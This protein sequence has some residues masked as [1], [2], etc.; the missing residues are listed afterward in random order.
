MELVVRYAVRREP[1]LLTKC[2]FCNWQL[3][4]D[5][6][7]SLVVN[8]PALLQHMASAHLKILAL[9][10]LPSAR[11]GSSASENYRRELI[12]SVPLENAEDASPN[13]DAPTLTQIEQAARAIYVPNDVFVPRWI[14]QQHAA[15]DPVTDGQVSDALQDK[16]LMPQVY[17]LL[18]GPTGVGKSTF[19]RTASGDERVGIGH[20]LNSYTI[21]V[22]AFEFEHAGYR[23]TLLDTPGFNDTH[24]GETEVLQSI[25]E[26]LELA[27][28]KSVH[29]G[30][31]GI[32]YLHSILDVP[33]SGSGLR[34]IRMFKKLI[35]QDALRKVVLV[36]ARWGQVAKLGD[37]KRAE[38]RELELRENFWAPMIQRGSRVAR[39]D[40]TKGSALAIIMSLIGQQTVSQ[41]SVVL[42]IQSELADRKLPLAATAAGMI[43]NDETNRLEKKYREELSNMQREMEEA[44]AQRDVEV[45]EA[46]QEAMEEHQRKLERVQAE[47]Q[48]LR[49]QPHPAIEEN[50]PSLQ[51]VQAI[52]DLPQG[53]PHVSNQE[54][55]GSVPPIPDPLTQA[56]N[57]HR[58]IVVVEYGAACSGIA[59]VI[60]DKTTVEDI[61]FVR[62]WPGRNGEWKVPTCIAY[63]EE[64]IRLALRDNVWGYQVESAM[65]SCSWTKLLLDRG[66]QGHTERLPGWVADVDKRG[67]CRVPSN[68]TAQ[69][70]CSDF[71]REL[72]RHLH[73]TLAKLMSDRE[74]EAT[75]MDCWIPVP[76]VFSQRAVHALMEAARTAGFGSRAG[77]TIS[78]ITEPE[79]AALA[80]L[81]E[82]TM[83]DSL[84]P[85]KQG[86]TVMICDCGGATTDTTTYKLT[87]ITPRLEFQE[88]C[89]LCGSLD[90]DRDFYELMWWRFGEAFEK[91]TTGSHKEPGERFQQSWNRLKR[92]F[93]GRE[94]SDEHEVG[95]LV[96]PGVEDSQYYDARKNIVMLS[97]EDMK[98]V[99]APVVDRIIK[100]LSTQQAEVE[101]KLGKRLDYI[102]LVGGLAESEYLYSRLELYCTVI[103]V[104]LLRP[105][106]PQTAVMRGAA[107]RAMQ[108]INPKIR[109]H[110]RHYGVVT[111][112]LFRE[113]IDRR[114]QR[115]YSATEGG[116][117]CRDR[118]L[119]LIHK[120]DEML[121]QM[122]REARLNF[123]LTEDNMWRYETELYACSSDRAPEHRDD[124]GVES[125]GR[126]V[127]DFSQVDRSLLRFKR[128]YLVIG[129]KTCMLELTLRMKYRSQTGDLELTSL[130]GDAVLSTA[131]INLSGIV[132][133]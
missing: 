30:L 16:P 74:L 120:G 129:R 69:Q 55:Q 96:M 11:S 58:L 17:I 27:Y 110:R 123:S 101:E 28:R 70:V 72:Y 21:D 43:I 132:D 106:Y 62:T 100:L 57:R 51:G 66:E 107:L 73:H 85:L 29:G 7:S 65:L 19:I 39:F 13:P 5:D 59:Y 3:P 49:G 18:M 50:Q 93:T 61:S 117:Q 78:V 67:I 23:V 115:F 60:G 64:N 86:E 91:S 121:P 25:A 20:G 46:L 36:T 102:I 31:A 24:R 44:L 63:A 92:T 87:E 80:A 97:S 14:A 94:I 53:Q 109:R 127:T 128:D 4:A 116:Y 118:M 125:V 76:A 2:A 105:K 71:L 77:D 41:E 26:Y 52:N 103:S 79:A 12:T 22:E 122:K 104:Q 75:P 81:Y 32:I 124:P 6:Q 8:Q 34:N 48:R 15:E 98:D 33:M 1:L 113:G 35:G 40:D 38:S 130:V 82:Y 90:L 131:I 95:Y 68:K 89:I 84:K 47:S 54:E 56:S 88:A 114:S 126:I 10:S 133:S 119:W 99:F 42:Q 45:Q 83:P 37:L 112:M 108:D 9:N 111:N